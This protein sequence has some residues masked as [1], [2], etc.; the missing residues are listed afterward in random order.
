MPRQPDGQE[1]DNLTMAKKATAKPT[2]SAEQALAE[3]LASLEEHTQRR[4]FVLVR[5]FD[6]FLSERIIDEIARSYSKLMPEQTTPLDVVLESDGG[7]ADAAYKA[8]LTLRSVA[9]DLRV[10]VPSWA[11]SAATLFALG[12]DGVAMPPAF[13]ELGPLDAQVIDPRNPA[14]TMSALD[15]YQSVEY[16]RDYALKTQSLAVGQILERTRSRVPLGEV[17]ERSDSFAVSVISPI[18]SQ[19]KPLDFGGWGRTLDI[20]RVY[21]ERL[22][23]RYGMAMHDSQEAAETA[24]RLVYGYPHH[25]FAIDLSEARE[26]GLNAEPMDEALHGLSRQVVERA[27]DCTQIVCDGDRHRRGPGYTGFRP[28]DNHSAQSVKSSSGKEARNGS[29]DNGEVVSGLRDKLAPKAK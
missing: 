5:P 13:A 1:R 21:A 24:Y 16:L 18:M 9:D 29:D 3:A 6:H 8:V 26:L 2:P 12:A 23:C 27:F 15:G 22:L 7:D 10:L 20:G 19:V 17:I 25:G 28:E 11:K 14:R 4:T